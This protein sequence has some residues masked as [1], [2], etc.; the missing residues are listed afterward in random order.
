MTKHESILFIVDLG[1][2]SWS[3]WEFP[4]IILLNCLDLQETTL[5]PV[6]PIVFMAPFLDRAHGTNN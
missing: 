6:Y 1:V 4:G 2:I 3:D 5:K